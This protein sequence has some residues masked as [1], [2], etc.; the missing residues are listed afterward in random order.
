MQSTNHN[1]SGTARTT[2]K[3]RLSKRAKRVPAKE[4][5]I[6]QE[7]VKAHFKARF[8]EMVL[9]NFEADAKLLKR[10]TPKGLEP[11][12]YQ[13]KG[14]IS[15][16]SKTVRKVRFKGLPLTRDFASLGLQ[17]YVRE[18]HADGYRFGTFFLKQYVQRSMA[19]WLMNKLT[20]CEITHM[21]MEMKKAKVPVNRPPDLQYLWKVRERL[22]DI[23]IRGRSRVKEIR[24]DTKLEYVL[25]HADRYVVNEK[26][27]W[28]S[29]L[30]T[31]EWIIWDVA[32]AKFDCD[33][34]RL[35]G[36]QFVKAMAKRPAS[37]FLSRGNEVAISKPELVQPA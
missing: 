17:L 9:I 35:F 15:L 11:D 21:P 26:G 10:I 6:A 3:P 14:H 25:R 22:N 37:V 28:R 4:Q 12:L 8:S 7:P 34:E 2:R 5:P 16:V 24:P 33:V 27:I 30:S 20:K 13:G 36:S 23:R 19:A 1:Q 32:Q 29:R 18:P 31:P